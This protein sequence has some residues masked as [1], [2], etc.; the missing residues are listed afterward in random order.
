MTMIRKSRWVLIAVILFAGSLV[1]QDTVRVMTYNLLQYFSAPDS[2]DPYFRTVIQATKPDLLV[3]EEISDPSSVAGFLTNVLNYGGTDEYG[4]GSF[5]ESPNGAGWGG[6]NELFYRKSKFSFIDNQAISTELRDINQFTVQHSSGRNLLVYA[7]HLKASN[8]AEDSAQRSREIE[9]L[10]TVTR[11]LPAGTDYI[12]TGDFNFYGDQ[13]PA[14]KKLT[15]PVNAAG[16]FINPIPM[17]GTWNSNQYTEFH[18]QSTRASLG[19]LD[20][21]FDLILVSKAVKDAGGITM[22]NPWTYYIAFGNDGKHYNQ[23]INLQPNTAVDTSVANALFYASDHLPVIASFTFDPIV[24]V[25]NP[26]VLPSSY[27]LSQNHPNPFNPSTELE[28]RVPAYGQVTLKVFDI[29]GHEIA[30]L[31]DDMRAPGTYR[32]SWD[33]SGMPSGVY[34][35]RMTA[36]SFVSTRKMVLL[37]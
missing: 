12:V 14:Y 3:V 10:M 1:A 2:R 31:V 11:A 16:T 19:G 15:L 5:I 17:N 13:E 33:A 30:S 25:S 9:N 18:T 8:T 36:G 37:Q 7:V 34:F 24:S 23:D 4:A 29:L 32:V 27:S 6:S 28:Y 26:S 35:Y 21:R 22:L 20:D